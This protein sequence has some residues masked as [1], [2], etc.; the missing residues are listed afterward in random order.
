[1]ISLLNSINDNI[2]SLTSVL[3]ARGL[4]DE[5]DDKD[6]GRAKIDED[7]AIDITFASMDQDA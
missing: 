7:V 6:K 5:D 4:L 1:M 3:K 2:M